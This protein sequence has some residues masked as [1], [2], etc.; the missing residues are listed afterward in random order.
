MRILYV[1]FNASFLNPTRNLLPFVLMRAGSTTLFGPGYVESVTLSR[2]LQAFVDAKGPFDV[3]LTNS[4][5]LF[6]DIHDPPLKFYYDLGFDLTDQLQLPSL[7]AAFG[8][9]SIP[10]IALFLETDYYDWQ[11][12]AEIEVLYRR[13]DYA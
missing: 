2:G 8:A 5:V 1:D 3:A 13:T 9:L 6:A 12:A 4:H 11:E 10:R 7:A